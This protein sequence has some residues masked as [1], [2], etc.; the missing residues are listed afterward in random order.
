M[1][2]MD[3]IY[4]P[5]QHLTPG[6]RLITTSWQFFAVHKAVRNVVFRS[7]AFSIFWT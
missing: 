4:L 2:S 5:L 6:L 3:M 7:A 1:S